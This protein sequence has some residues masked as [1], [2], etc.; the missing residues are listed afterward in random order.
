MASNLANIS[1]GGYDLNWLEDPPADLKCLICLCVARD[2]HQHP[3]DASNECGKVFCHGCITEYKRKK[4]TCPNCRRDLTLFKDSRSMSL[5]MNNRIVYKPFYVAG[6]RDIKALKVKCSSLVNGCLWVRELGSLDAHL[7][8]C[9]Y[10]L[11]PCTNE[12]KIDNEIAFLRK[13]LE[14]HLTN[15]C[16]RRQYKCPLCQEKGEHQERT[17]THLETCPKVEVPC[18]NNQCQDNIA[19]CNVKAHRSRCEY[20]PVSCKYADVGCKV[21]PLRKDLKKHE[22]DV[23]L[24]LQVTVDKVLELTNNVALIEANAKMSMKLQDGTIYNVHTEWVKSLT[25]FTRTLRYCDFQQHK[26]DNIEFYT[27]PFYTSSKGYK[28]CVCVYAN[29]FD[30]AKG[31]HVSLFAHLMKGDN[32]D[33]LSWPFTGTITFELLNQLEDKNHHKLTS[34]FT[35]NH[36]LSQR[37]VDDEIVSNGYGWPQYIS[38]TALDYNADNNTS[39]LKDDALVFRFSVKVPTLLECSSYT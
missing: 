3:G 17:T 4:T 26:L 27:P 34:T 5:Y 20:E 36:K 6:A 24:H 35:A 32:D 22:E 19:R 33:S 37:V 2:P 38:H 15:D 25:N 1:V 11:L 21:Q 8:S 31:T 16:P 28:M 23:Q 29:G 9:D 10:A 7:Q 30:E 12:C 39:Y 14:E 18:P 13:D